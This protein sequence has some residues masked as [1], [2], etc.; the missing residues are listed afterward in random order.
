MKRV[1]P[2]VIIAGVLG[3]ALFAVWYLTRSEA[4]T[5]RVNSRGESGSTSRTGAVKLGAQPPN[6]LGD[7]NAPVML[8][9]FG[10][11]ECPP[12]GSL[13][14]V[15]K[16]MK[17]EFG[18]SVVIVFREFP[19]AKHA[20]ALAAARAA[21]AAGLQGRFW[22]MHDLL[23]ENQKVWHEASDVRPI[24]EEYATQT[25]LSLERF[26]RD[27]MSDIVTQRITLDRERGHSIG[28]NSTPTVFLN[29]REVPP[30]SLGTYKLRELIKAQIPSGNRD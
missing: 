15:L 18:P 11:F 17:M 26:R 29:G 25:G 30:E 12:C 7:P 5:L 20:H 21:E 2:I 13:H 16:S 28:I 9:E 3:A 23:Y 24:F 27:S 19:L 1:L 8:E 10:D 4:E 6:T 14:P 22:Q